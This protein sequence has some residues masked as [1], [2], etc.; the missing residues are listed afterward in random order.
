MLRF[1]NHQDMRIL[2]FGHSL[3]APRQIRFWKY[4][5]SL[6]HTVRVLAPR[7]WFFHEV[8]DYNE[9]NFNIK[10]VELFGDL[11]V[12]GLLDLAKD[13]QPDWVYSNEPT[14][15]GGSLQAVQV[16][17]ELGIK[18][19]VFDWDNIY[20]SSP[21]E[22]KVLEQVDLLIPGCHGAKGI[23][24]QKG[25][26]PLKVSEPILQV[27]VDTE[28][29]KPVECEKEY[30]TVTCARFTENKGV[31]DIKRVVKKL[32]LKHLWL[33]GTEPLDYGY[34]AGW[35]PYEDLPKWYCKAKTH[36][37]FSRDTPDWKEQNAPYSNLEALACGLSVVMSRAGDA[38]YFLEGC[39]A[40]R[41]IP[42]NNVEALEEGV[43]EMLN[44]KGENGRDFVVRHYGYEVTAWRLVKA[45]ESIN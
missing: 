28:L 40:V 42:Q 33:G 30:D 11:R 2:V 31:N 19:A 39:K 17:K 32:S 21:F 34:V 15:S 27:G 7:K 35:Q 8:E 22:G 41:L 14:Y 23:L 36:I 16:G 24:L 6:G 1:R 45:F 20:H 25:V 5:A 3:C 43:K 38:P 4:F 18:V 10:G 44:Y 9:G 29:F 37:L 12:R 13:F 26:S